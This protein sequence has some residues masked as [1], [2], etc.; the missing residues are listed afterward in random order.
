MN[1]IAALATGLGIPAVLAAFVWVVKYLVMAQREDSKAER[2]AFREEM[3]DDRAAFREELKEQRQY[4]SREAAE[5]REVLK[6]L[7]AT[8]SRCQLHTTGS[9]N[10]SDQN[11]E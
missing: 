8:I 7:T 9:S 3:R 11:E 4:Q 10:P 6:D 5:Y 1:D 2:C